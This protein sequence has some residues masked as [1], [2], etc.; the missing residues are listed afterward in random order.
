MGVVSLT[1]RWMAT[2]AAV[3][4]SSLLGFTQP[5]LDLCSVFVLLD[6]FVT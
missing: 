2:Q 1:D 5:E 3:P 4:A 6:L